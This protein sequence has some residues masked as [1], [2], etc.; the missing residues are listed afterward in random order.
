M[1]PLQIGL[2]QEAAVFTQDTCAGAVSL[3][4]GYGMGFAEDEPGTPLPPL[5][6]D[7]LVPET[8]DQQ[9]LRLKA[10]GA[11]V[12]MLCAYSNT[13]IAAIEAAHRVRIELY[14]ILTHSTI[15]G[16]TFRRAVE[17]GL[18]Q[19]NYALGAV[20]WHRS[21]PGVGEFSG[22]NSS[23]FADTYRDRF[24]EEAPYQAAAM[25]GVGCAL[26]R[27]IETAD[28]TDEAAVAAALREMD[29]VEFYARITFDEFGQM[30][31]N[32][33]AMQFIDDVSVLGVAADLV[34]PLP[35]WAQRECMQASVA[36]EDTRECYG[37]GRCNPTGECVCNDGFEGV[38]CETLSPQP[39]GGFSNWKAL[40]T[41]AGALLFV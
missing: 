29:M 39:D 16:G 12:L 32:V 10:A 24:F 26:G 9:L 20:V 11:N 31:A 22:K 40:L 17:G 2:L 15:D 35:S 4:P 19:G 14:A 21:L 33:P 5:T 6:I 37:Q 41:G 36:E 3:A 28:S 38:Y 1:S 7:P 27:A 18:W 8:I 13:V 23:W 34:F 25:F 30:R